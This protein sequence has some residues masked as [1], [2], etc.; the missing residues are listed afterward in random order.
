MRREP[1][2]RRPSFRRIAI[3]LVSCGAP[4]FAQGTARALPSEGVQ[5]LPG[6]AREVSRSSSASRDTAALE[7][8]VAPRFS[9]TLGTELG[10][11]AWHRSGLSLR[12]GALALFGLESQTRSRQ[13][14]PAPGGDSNLWRG[15]LGYELSLSFDRIAR[16]ALGQHG[17]LEI[18]LGY[19]HESDH[20]T[21]SNDPV[22]PG[23]GPDHPELRGRPQ[24]GNSL[25]ADF[26]SRFQAGSL[27]LILRQQSKL[28]VN[29]P[30][31]DTTPFRAGT[32]QEL[33]LQLH[34]LLPGVTPF[35]S[36]A[37]EVLLAKGRAA[38]RD[39]RT[40]LG[41]SL[42]GVTGELRLYASFDAGAEKGLLITE[43]QNA[44]GAGF[45]YTPFAPEWP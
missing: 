42:P 21:A 15:I 27:E 7:A 28:F 10:L 4:F 9:V 23:L 2:G 30:A 37:A 32:A 38:T 29:G 24:I 43:R 19:Y 13:L 18:A 41:V 5:W 26:A 17:G 3:L 6:D 8:I 34:Q 20:H 12:G 39:F 1:A 14:F 40:L 16:L 25:A 33:V 35:W 22:T 44:L 45:R 36:S 31:T 11:V